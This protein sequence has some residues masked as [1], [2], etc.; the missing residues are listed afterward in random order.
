MAYKISKSWAPSALIL[1]ALATLSACGG[2][3]TTVASVAPVVTLPTTALVFSNGQTADVVIGQVNFVSGMNNQG[4]TAAANTVYAPYGNASVDTTG[5]LYLGDYG[6][7]RILVYNSIPTANNA[8]ASFAIGQPNLTT[9]N[10]NTTATGLSGP[11]QVSTSSGGKLAVVDFPNHRVAIYNTLPT[12]GPGT[13][14]VVVGQ[15]NKTTGLNNCT[16]QGLDSPQSAVIV[17]TK[18]LVADQ[19]NNRVLIWNSIPTSDGQV[20]DLVLGQTNFTSC[21]ANP[22]GITGA[23]T[24]DA[25][26][27]IW[28]DGTR[29]V[30]VDT[31]NSRVLIWNTFPTSNGQNADLVLGQQNFTSR[32]ENQGGMASASTLAYPFAGV[33]SSN[34]QLFITDSDNN[35]VLVW[36]T[37]P[38]ANGQAADK[39]IG[40]P[41]FVTTTNNLT[42]TGLDYPSGVYLS[43]KKLIVTDSDNGRYLVYTG[44]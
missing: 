18:L 21:S 35:R 3:D 8:Q 19:L 44:L 28:T 17:G 38:I 16:S 23:G 40:Q 26:S 37:W 33:Y 2:G 39:V 9:A 30:V 5:K 20:A 15:P 43:G 11:I 24:L 27:G 12:G 6:N 34:N 31:G 4:G 32:N 14:D 29:L 36:N 41:G 7:N 25:L 1:A 22:G 13:I 10:A 42:A